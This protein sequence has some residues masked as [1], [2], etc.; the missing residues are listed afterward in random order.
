MSALDQRVRIAAHQAQSGRLDLAV[1][2][3][4]AV[5]Q[6]DP[7]HAE[8]SRVLAMAIFQAGQHQQGLALMERAAAA[9]PERGDILFMLASMHAWMGQIPKA[10]PVLRRS[11]ELDPAQAQ[12]RALLATCL[13]QSGDSDAAED[14]YRAALELEP[15][16]AE[17][18]TN[19]GAIMNATARSGEAVKILRQAA[20][21]HPT[22]P[23]V[24]TNYC[25]VLNY[26]DNIA[27][28]EIVAAHTHYGRVLATLPVTARSPLHE[29]RDPDKRLRIGIISPDLFE[30]SVGYYVRAML[31]RRDRTAF[32]YW[33]YATSQR[34]DAAT[35]RIRGLVDQWRDIPPRTVDQTLVDLIRSDN[36]DIL[37]ELSGHTLGHRQPALRM[38]AAPVQVTY[39]GYPNTTGVQAMDYR[40][41]DSITDP[42]G[43][44]ARATEKLIRLDP[45]F[46]CYTPPDDAPPVAS[47]PFESNGVITFGSFNSVKKI[48]PTTAALWAAALH[49]VPGARLVIKSGGFGSPRARQAV[50][51]MLEQEGIPEARFDLLGR[52]DSRSGHLGAYERLDIALDTFPYHGTT[53][54]CEAMWMGVPVISLE[55]QLHAGRVGCSLLRA[56]GLPDL[57]ASSREEFAA[58]AA[59]LAADHDRLREMRQGMRERMAASPLCDQGAFCRRFEAALR[60]MWRHRCAGAVA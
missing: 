11:I 55:G 2:A 47:S 54:T 60:G 48:T 26:A 44:E 8:A 57:V 7:T 22:H 52:V 39:I 25:V 14:E 9:A 23:G 58:A 51:Q 59:R 21:D 3:L 20:I 19:Y 36:I 4:K 43:A 29:N 13:L 34:S 27:P 32:E 50:A 17:A 12:P 1:P 46:L 6:Q 42:A 35:Q 18:R 33:A 28:E 40:I 53:T 45:C 15:K 30:H 41:V 10:I 24:L 56:V 31:E 37:I 38:R 5:L 49:A 16:H